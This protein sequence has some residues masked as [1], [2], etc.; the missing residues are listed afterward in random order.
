M[1]AALLLAAGCARTRE[2]SRSPA[3]DH[4]AAGASAALTRP[5]LSVPPAVKTEHEHLHHELEGGV[6]FVA[7]GCCAHPGA[8]QVVRP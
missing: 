2:Q 8:A 3:H 1:I 5:L 7:E 4:T 6:G